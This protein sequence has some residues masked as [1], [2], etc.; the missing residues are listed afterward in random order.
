MVVAAT[1]LFQLVEDERLEQFQRHLLGQPALMQTQLRTDHDHRTAGIVHPL[2]QEILPEPPLLSL[3]HVAEGLERTL[4]GAP[5]R[6]ATPAVVEQGIDRF[7][8]HPHFIPNDDA[9]RLQ[10]HAGA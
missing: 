8:Q 4:V 10:L 5:N 1:P 9:G 7:L 2:S 6:T 3:E